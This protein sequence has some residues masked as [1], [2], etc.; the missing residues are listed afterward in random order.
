MAYRVFEM[1]G[2]DAGHLRPRAGRSY[3]FATRAAADSFAETAFAAAR[4]TNSPDAFTYYTV[5][6]LPEALA[7]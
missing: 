3:D 2:Y 1:T 6:E 7:A 5:Q 4:P